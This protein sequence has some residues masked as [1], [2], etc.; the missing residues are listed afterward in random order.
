[1]TTLTPSSQTIVIE[2]DLFVCRVQPHLGASIHSFDIKLTD[3]ETQPLL[4]HTAQEGSTDV[5]DFSCWPLVPYSNRINRGRFSFEGVSYEATPNY[6]GGPNSMH[7]SH[8]QGWQFPWTVESASQTHCT[9]S[10]AFD[11]AQP[12][13]KGLWP[14]AYSAREH[15][16]LTDEGMLLKLSV[17]NTGKTNMPSGL[18]THPYFPKVQG[19]TLQAVVQK[20]WE[21]DANVIPVKHVDV[22]AEYDFS[23]PKS[24]D[25][26]KLDSCF[27]GYGGL[28]QIVWPGRA[29]A[30]NVQSSPNLGH[31]VVYTPQGENFFCAEPVSHKPDAINDAD[32]GI[33]N[34]LIVLAPGQTQ[35]IWYKYEAVRKPDAP[36]APSRL[37]AWKPLNLAR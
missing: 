9:L 12:S 27:S 11:P 20:L 7:A 30:L 4:R 28:M 19:T 35:E 14:F 34:G 17:T 31:Y 23:T 36:N 25:N 2:N 37:K 22:P 8:G 24:L 32:G 18:G 33:A 6:L 13:M 15:I 1:M 3:G 21:I 29:V 10:F 26:A 5:L 16:E